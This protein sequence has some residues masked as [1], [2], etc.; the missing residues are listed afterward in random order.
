MN[1]KL[2]SL[3]LTTLFVLLQAA[4]NGNRPAEITR[5]GAREPAKAPAVKIRAAAPPAGDPHWGYEQL[6]GPARWGSLSPEWAV[7]GA[8]KTQSPIDIKQT[9]KADLPELRADFKPAALKIVHHEHMADV[10]NTGHSIQVNYTEGDTLKVGG[11][12]FQLLQ[13]HFHSPSEHTVGGKQF[14]MEMHLVHRSAGGKLAVVG[15]FIEEGKHNAAFDPVWS[16]LPNAKSVEHHLEHLKVDV[17]DLLPATKTTF[18]YDGSLTTPPCSEGVKWII[19]TDP[20]QLSA[21]Q[22]GAFRSILKGN[23]RPVQPLNARKVATDRIAE[24]GMKQ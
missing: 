15:V 11:E 18:R 17:N 14:P 12:E 4:C 2:L 19:M 10:I 24:T 23:N 21:Q 16:N 3:G 20:I 8:G 13:Y 5:E 1:G 9:V 7:C 6:E 22:I